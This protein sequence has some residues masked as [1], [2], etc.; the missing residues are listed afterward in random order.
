MLD[1]VHVFLNSVGRKGE[2]VLNSPISYGFLK[3]IFNREELITLC[4]FIW[5]QWQML[6]NLC[7]CIYLCSPITMG[8][9]W[10]VI[11]RL[12]NLFGVQIVKLVSHAG[13]NS[14]SSET[15]SPGN[16]TIVRGM[17]EAP[18]VMVE[19]AWLWEWA[20]VAQFQRRKGVASR[21]PLRLVF[22][23]LETFCFSEVASLRIWDPLP[24]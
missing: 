5:L 13:R 12:L 24:L 18:S 11:A 16:Q 9:D 15:D 7:N 14:W 10:V 20:R 3:G 17:C 21:A 6:S 23:A 8:R 1:C 22:E 4:R 19:G 2:N